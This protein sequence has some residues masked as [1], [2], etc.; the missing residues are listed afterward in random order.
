[1]YF[2]ARWEAGHG[3]LTTAAETLSPKQETC[4]SRQTLQTHMIPS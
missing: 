2:F 4:T 3:Q 1:M